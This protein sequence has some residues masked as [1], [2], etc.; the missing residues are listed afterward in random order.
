MTVREKRER[1]Q[2]RAANRYQKPKIGVLDKILI[3]V[4]I[5]L[6][7]F[8][9]VMIVIFCRFG[10]IPDTLCTCVFA[11]CTGELG[12]TGMIHTVKTKYRD[13]LWQKEDQE[14]EES[15]GSKRSLG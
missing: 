8:V 10:A 1:E 13:R 6:V 12:I 5:F 3:F 2:R 11:A 4:G 7:V 14:A 15:S 9:L